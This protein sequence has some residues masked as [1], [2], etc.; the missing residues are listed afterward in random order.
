MSTTDSL[1]DSTPPVISY[2]KSESTE[3]LAP[4]ES[5]ELA[6]QAAKKPKKSVQ[7]KPDD[8]LTQIRLF[9]SSDVVTPVIFFYL[10]NG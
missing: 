9:D 7:F 5:Q 8:R 4:E 3:D 10:V 6:T 1:Q 2:R